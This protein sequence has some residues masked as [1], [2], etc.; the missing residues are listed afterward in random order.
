MSQL[1]WRG[2]RDGVS[3]SE[4]VQNPLSVSEPAKEK[5]WEH[6][7]LEVSITLWVSA[8]TGDHVAKG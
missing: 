1:L 8:T 5:P 4:V 7:G 6:S 3:Q 2:F